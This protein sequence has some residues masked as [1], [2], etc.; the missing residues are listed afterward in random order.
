MFHIDNVS[1][2]KNKYTKFYLESLTVIQLKYICDCLN[3]TKS[4]PKAEIIKNIIKSNTHDIAKI[5]NKVKLHD[6]TT[7]L[8]LK[9]LQH[10]CK[11]L[12]I[13]FTGTKQKLCDKIFKCEPNFEDIIAEIKE[14]QNYKYIIKC[15]SG[16]IFYA[17][18][19]NQKCIE[20][21]CQSSILFQS[22]NEF[23]GYDS[24]ENEDDSSENEDDSS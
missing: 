13:N 18:K 5:K 14:Y 22:D 4:G 1:S 10:V 19:K 11:M 21:I 12:D 2:K 3:I 9:E 23:Y 17:N 15:F 24:S 8:S 7:K 16:H 6:F 20:K